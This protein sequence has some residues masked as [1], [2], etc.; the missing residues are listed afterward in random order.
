MAH[1]VGLLGLVTSC[2]GVIS[3]VEPRYSEPAN[4]AQPFIK[5]H[6]KFC[7]F[8][9]MVNSIIKHEFGVS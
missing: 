1:F 5:S 8:F 7:S 9:S 2:T 6:N 3:T 4:K